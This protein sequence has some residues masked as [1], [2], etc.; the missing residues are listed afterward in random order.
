[1]KRFLTILLI[2]LALGGAWTL[3]AQQD[4]ADEKLEPISN[5]VETINVSIVNIDVVVTDKKGSSIQGLM[6]EDFEI[7]DNGRSQPITNFYEVKGR[8]IIDHRPDGEVVIEQLDEE[9]LPSEVPER[10]QR[11][12]VFFVDN[13]SLAPFNRQPVFKEMKKFV[14]ENLLPGD[15]A[16][17][18]TFNRDIKVRVPFTDDH[19][20]IKQ[21]F[22]TI[23]EENAFGL[24]NLSERRQAESSIRDAVN[25]DEALGIA[26]SFAYSVEHDLRTAI[27][28]MKGLMTTLAGVDGRKIM[29]VTSEGL[30]IQPGRE[31]FYYID[32]IA[33]QKG[34]R[35]SSSIHMEAT[36]FDSKLVIES[37][38]QA[39]NANGIT[40]YLLHAGG[41]AASS[42]GTS[43]ESAAPIPPIVATAALT[44]STESM[45]L[46]AY[47][48]G[49]VATVGTNN[50]AGAFERIE[51][52]I[53]SYYSLGYRAGAERI[54]R[55]RR[56][57]VRVKNK[58]YRVRTRRS[59]VEKSVY[60]E[61]SDRVIA[62][63][64][65]RSDDNGLGLAMKTGR[66]QP[67]EGD[68]F[69]VPIEI[70]IPMEK[71]AFIPTGEVARGG[72]AVFVVV[73]DEQGDMS[74]V[75]RMDQSIVL[76]L[77]EIKA[78]QGKHYTYTADLLMG[79]GRNKISVAVLDEAS[80][81]T[82][83]TTQEVLAMDL[84]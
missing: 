55:Q 8:S 31:L 81:M 25:Y 44:N 47:M 40:L 9:A 83:Y 32:E 50:F 60:T 35:S 76:D 70:R 64:F 38:A 17:I 20:F 78:L 54:D 65:Y 30:P 79:K 63:L 77:E 73:A 84:R 18:A 37:L 1:V 33:G 69:I 2:S 11:R 41:L 51:S 22:D 53:N 43:A 45:N 5:F 46:L 49:G 58:D 71:L 15:L 7:I 13:L 4:P 48:T 23:A 61:L 14:D 6:R 56:I 75:Q 62:N 16:M 72:F 39:A 42:V 57:E 3:V 66:A 19:T 29:V 10:L 80:Q 24:Q 82:G 36:H 67:V 26:R 27:G 12:Y 59:L 21:T 68:R 28:A 74:E 34:W 52:D